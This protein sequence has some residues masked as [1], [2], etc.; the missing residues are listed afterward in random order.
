M[1]FDL[2]KMPGFGAN[3]NDDEDNDE[4]GLADMVKN[5]MKSMFGD[6]I[7]ESI[8]DLDPG[9]LTNMML[10]V[11]QQ[12]GMFMG[13]D[14]EEDYD[15]VDFDELLNSYSPECEDEADTKLKEAIQDW[16]TFALPAVDDEEIAMLGVEFDDDCEDVSEMFFAYHDEDEPWDMGGW[17]NG[18][19][20]S[21][22]EDAVVNWFNAKGVDIN[23]DD[24]GYADRIF[25]IIVTAVKE[26][27]EDGF[28]KSCFGREIPF[29]I[30]DGRYD[31][32]TALWTVKANGREAL[33]ES[34]FEECGLYDDDDGASELGDGHYDPDDPA[35]DLPSFGDAFID[36]DDEDGS[37]E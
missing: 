27:I 28:I 14:D 13:G 15:E 7:P 25:D 1:D 29:V 6:S 4:G 33:D 20:G 5:M 22:E 35:D 19:A 37:D 18:Y 23:S 12:L 24:H 10:D 2:E 9:E 32:R 8:E 26:L 31:Y 21:L 3:G 17:L 36:F 34:F 16:L 30:T 11:E